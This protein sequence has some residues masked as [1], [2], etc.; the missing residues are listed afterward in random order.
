MV[1][2]KTE[3]VGR[4][5]LPSCLRESAAEWYNSEERWR[6]IPLIEGWENHSPKN[7]IS[8]LSP[9]DKAEVDKTFDA[10]HNDGTMSYATGHTPSAYPV[11]VVWRSVPQPDGTT[12]RK[13]R[14]VVD[15]RGLNK[16]TVP[17]VY[18]IPTL[19]DIP[20]MVQGKPYVTVMDAEKFFY[21]VRTICYIGTGWPSF[22]I[23][24]RRLFMS[25]SWDFG[26]ASHTCSGSMSERICQILSCVFP[27]ALTAHYIN[28]EVGTAR[29]IEHKMYILAISGLT[30]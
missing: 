12:L 10:I 5:N 16:I 2:L 8:H 9:K 22:H 27:I 4:A 26:V 24:D 1:L 7:K 28:G 19:D 13:A 20:A 11:F 15:I 29:A 3:E 17:D 18:P 25:R 30:P 23:G 6:T 21:H 14:V